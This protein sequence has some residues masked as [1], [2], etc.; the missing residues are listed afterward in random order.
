MIL[1]KK[2][3][4]FTTLTQQLL[5]DNATTNTIC[6]PISAAIV[7]SM[8]AYGA[9]ENTEKQLRT[10]L[11][12][13]VNDT[14]AKNGFQTLIDTLNVS[15]LVVTIFFF[16]IINNS[17]KLIYRITRELNYAWPIKFSQNMDLK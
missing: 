8:A 2:F 7:L 15:F 17:V 9:R 14:L 16:L 5:S 3:F 6:S 11:H 4:F 12:L 13:P 10:V 1:L